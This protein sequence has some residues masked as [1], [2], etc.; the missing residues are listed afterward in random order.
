MTPKGECPRICF[1]SFI[2]IRYPLCEHL[3]EFAAFSCT[4]DS[5]FREKLSMYGVSVDSAPVSPRL[6]LGVQMGL[7]DGIRAALGKGKKLYDILDKS[8]LKARSTG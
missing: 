7:S 1:F 4:V 5:A 6:S 8:Q 2:L 3:V